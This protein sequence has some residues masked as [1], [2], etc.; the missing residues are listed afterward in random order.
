ML[1]LT[2]VKMLGLGLTTNKTYKE[3]TIQ[4]YV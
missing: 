1:S 2:K 4:Q 3:K